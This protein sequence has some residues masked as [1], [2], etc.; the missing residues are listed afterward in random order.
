[1]DAQGQSERDIVLR[2]ESLHKRYGLIDVLKGVDL[3]VRAG[4]RICIIGPSGSGKSTL[5]RCINFLEEY[6]EG[7]ILVNGEEIAFDVDRRGR[8]RR[9][10][11]SQLNRMRSRI[12]MVFQSFNLWPNMTALENVT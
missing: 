8:R 10:P 12:G 7:R 4:E 3:Q 1:M 11:E 9:R 5:L 6:D 2:I